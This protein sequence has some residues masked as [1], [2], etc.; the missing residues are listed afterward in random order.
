MS[1]RG[2]AVPGPSRRRGVWLFALLG[3]GVLATVAGLVALLVV[4]GRGGESSAPAGPSPPAEAQEQTPTPTL[5][6]AGS[7]LATT[8]NGVETSELS[9]GAASGQEEAGVDDPTATVLGYVEAIDALLERSARTRRRVMRLV[10][11]V[12][13]PSLS[14]AEAIARIEGVIAD[15]EAF[16]AELA[17]LGPP[18]AAFERAH[19]LLDESLRLSLEDNHA[20]KQWVVAYFGEDRL[21]DQLMAAHQAASLAASRAKERFLREYNARRAELGLEPLAPGLRY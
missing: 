6:S 11:A 4:P 12:G 10:A 13:T 18:P 5:Q 8:V 17:G 3:A 19:R 2:K 16:R 20:I 1:A 7:G 15:R 21:E 9:A 14:L